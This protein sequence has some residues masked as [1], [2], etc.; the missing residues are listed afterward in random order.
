MSRI[1]DHLVEK[2]HLGVATPE[3]RA[4]VEADP[5]AR[6]R[7]AALPEQDAAFFAE[8]PVDATVRAIEAR[9]ARSARRATPV[10]AWLA[11]PV[12]L[13]AAALLVV[14]ISG[15]P[16]APDAGPPAGLEPTTEK[17]AARAARMAIYRQRG[18]GPE[19][20][21]Q[22]DVVMPGDTLQVT[23]LGAKSGYG[24]VLSIDGRGA[25]TLHSPEQPDGPTDMTGGEYR[26]PHAYR[27]DDAP[28]YERFFLVT[29]PGPT[30]V[31]AVLRAA[32]GLAASGRADASDLVLPDGYQQTSTLV[33]K[34]N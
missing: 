28:K 12:A 18:G 23:V 6:A 7:L 14:Q 26:L 27:L 32:E 5:D 24:V 19:R 2:V 22:G 9:A 1:T 13:A 21:L 15:E 17:G 25:V 11:A 4:R 3:E 8:H 31:R 30:D 33:R 16:S 20:L 29:S 34:V 10:A